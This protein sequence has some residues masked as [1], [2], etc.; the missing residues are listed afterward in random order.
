MEINKS[1]TD[2][3]FIMNEPG[4]TLKD[5]FE[6]LI[7]DSRFFDVIVGYFYIIGFNAFAKTPEINCRGILREI[8]RGGIHER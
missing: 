8:E 2:L 5:R 6:T 3:T 1:F 7:K 4:K